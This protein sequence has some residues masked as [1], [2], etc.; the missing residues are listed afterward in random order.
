VIGVE[1]VPESWEGHLRLLQTV[2]KQ[3]V[4]GYCNAFTSLTF[5]E[6]RCS[7]K[8]GKDNTLEEGKR[9]YAGRRGKTVQEARSM[10][11]TRKDF[12]RWTEDQ[13]LK[14]KRER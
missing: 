11:M 1:T 6:R 7:W 12:S 2:H 5:I 9:Q 13:T 14:G 4:S 3:N 10:A 8:K